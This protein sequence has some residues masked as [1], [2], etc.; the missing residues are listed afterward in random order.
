MPQDPVDRALRDAKEN[1]RNVA[2]EA[3]GAVKDVT[4][5]TTDAFSATAN[6]FERA[7]R[8]TIETQPYTAVLIGVG[9]GWL[10]G[11]FHRPF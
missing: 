9:V 1:A 10:L 11:R 4:D 3:R 5:A 7:L 8:T 2:R 6:S